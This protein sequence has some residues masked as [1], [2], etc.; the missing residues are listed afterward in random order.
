MSVG[1]V[2]FQSLRS[3]SS[4][5]KCQVPSLGAKYLGTL[6]IFVSKPKM[7]KVGKGTE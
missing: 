6:P 7:V 3:S 5:A 2:T 1:D 4:S